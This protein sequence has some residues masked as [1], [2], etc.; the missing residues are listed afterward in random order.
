[1]ARTDKHVKLTV[2]VAEMLT[3]SPEHKDMFCF[4][5]VKIQSRSTKHL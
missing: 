5:T 2:A 4:A 3:Q 1:M